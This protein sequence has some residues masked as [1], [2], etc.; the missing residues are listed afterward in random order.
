MVHTFD[1]WRFSWSPRIPT[2]VNSPHGP[3]LLRD[4]RL[5]YA[6]KRLSGENRQVG[7][8]ESKDDGRTWE[9]LAEIPLRNGDKPRYHELHAVEA[10][11][12]TIVVQ[13]RNHND[14]NKGWTLQT[15]SIDGGRSRSQPHPV[16]DPKCAMKA[17][18]TL[19]NSMQK[20]LIHVKRTSCGP[21][22]G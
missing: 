3:I 10:D 4:G 5:L 20:S 11:N 22:T 9:W 1:G 17:R 6:G 13:I 2:L 14:E 18:H 7:V 8:C 19:C 16:C 12:G 15:E 21:T